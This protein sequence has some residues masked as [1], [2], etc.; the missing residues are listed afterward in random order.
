VIQSQNRSHT[1][2][3]SES[4]SWAVAQGGSLLAIMDHSLGKAGP[5][6]RTR[7]VDISREILRIAET[8]AYTGASS[9]LTSFGLF[10]SP[11]S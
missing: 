10:G 1:G 11:L 9:E 4:R 7:A 3:P 6:A 5:Q 2:Q 8:I